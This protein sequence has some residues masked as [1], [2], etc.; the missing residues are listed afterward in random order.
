LRYAGRAAGALLLPL[1]ARLVGRRAR[2]VIG[3]ASLALSTAGQT[4]VQGTTSASVWAFLFGV[5]N[6]WNDA[7][8]FVLAMDASDPRMAAS[9]FAIFMA[10]SNLSVVGDDLF[11]EAVHALGGLYRPVFLGA[12]VLAMALIALV[13]ALSRTPAQEGPAHGDAPR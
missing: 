8:F 10:V 13:P 3:L 2:L 7:L 11:L 5:S 6:G 9:T 4:L 12:S 1:A